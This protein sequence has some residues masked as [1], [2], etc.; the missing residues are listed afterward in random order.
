MHV[1]T[2]CDTAANLARTVDRQGM[3]EFEMRVL[4]QMSGADSTNLIDTPAA[5]NLGMHRALFHDEESG[6]L[7]K[8]RPY[9]APGTPLPIANAIP[10]PLN[11]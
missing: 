3:R 11:P 4:F 2:W 5:S 9:A 6:V 8:F 10:R 7:E 1:L